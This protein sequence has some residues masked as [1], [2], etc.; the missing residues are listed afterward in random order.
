MTQEIKKIWNELN[1]N[2]VVNKRELVLGITACSLAGILLG[3]LLCPK[4][5]VTIGSNN[6]S[7]NTGNSAAL[8][9]DPAI[10]GEEK[11]AE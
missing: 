6:G 10:P 3:M 5:S 1:Q 2:V 9:Q 4:K 8:P 11:D 7:N